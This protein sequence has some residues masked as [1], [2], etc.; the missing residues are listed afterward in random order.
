MIRLK[1]ND[2]KALAIC[3]EK[4]TAF[5]QE[6][7]IMDYSLYVV[8][9]HLREPLPP[10]SKKVVTGSQLA[11]S[12]MS[13]SYRGSAM[14]SRGLHRSQ[15]AG[16]TTSSAIATRVLRRRRFNEFGRNVFVSKDRTLVYHIGIIDYLQEWNG[17]KKLE[18]LY[19]RIV[20]RQQGNWISAV[21]PGYYRT[22]FVRE[23][24]HSVL[25]S[26]QE[27]S[28]IQLMWKDY[29]KKIKAMQSWDGEC[30]TPAERE[31]KDEEKERHSKPHWSSKKKQ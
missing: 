30:F 6:L 25:D 27:H 12:A 10:P 1:E 31:G 11:E 2:L 23:M 4:D 9:E 13:V 21:E 26:N 22:R 17:M 8:V 29:E 3:L 16:S 28:Q 14:D 20:R 19:K 7:D 15:A 24:I 5:L 18:R